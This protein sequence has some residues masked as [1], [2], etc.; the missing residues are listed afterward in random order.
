MQFNLSRAHWWS[1]L[2]EGL[3]RSIEKCFEIYACNI[4]VTYQKFTTIVIEIEV[5]LNSQLFTFV[6]LDD[7][8]QCLIPAHLYCVYRILTPAN[9]SGAEI[10]IIKQISLKQQWHILQTNKHFWKKWRKQYLLDIREISSK[11]LKS[12]GV[13]VEKE[14]VGHIY[15]ENQKKNKCYRASNKDI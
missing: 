4:R 2:F 15:E 7:L 3:I 1:G 9:F 8:Q 12:R 6:S 11:H 10:E 13:D 5:V 14:D